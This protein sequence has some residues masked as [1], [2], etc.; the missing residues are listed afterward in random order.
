MIKQVPDDEMSRQRKQGLQQKV[1][2]AAQVFLAK[3]A[4]LED[5][6]RFLTTVNNEGKVRRSTRSKIL[7]GARVMSY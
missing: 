7:G 2:N 1:K 6:N 5:Q 4:L 3:N